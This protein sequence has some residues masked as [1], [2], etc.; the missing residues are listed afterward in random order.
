MDVKTTTRLGLHI[1]GKL[2]YDHSPSKFSSTGYDCRS[3]K[4]RGER[5]SEKL[6]VA[7]KIARSV[8]LGESWVQESGSFLLVPDW[9]YLS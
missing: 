7:T 8:L 4:P 3:G 1:C 5:L 9:K 6:R 2:R